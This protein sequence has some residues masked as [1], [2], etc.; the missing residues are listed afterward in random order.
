MVWSPS[1]T[2]SSAVSRNVR[3]VA[4]LLAV[5]TGCPLAR[6]GLLPERFDMQPERLGMHP[7]R[8]ALLPERFGM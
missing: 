7:E 2:R 6:F 3:P 1:S 8:F 4:A 5:V